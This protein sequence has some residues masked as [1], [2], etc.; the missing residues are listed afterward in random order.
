MAMID[1]DYDYSEYT[2]TDDYQSNNVS[3]DLWGD[4]QKYNYYFFNLFHLMV[5]GR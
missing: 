5:I 2:Q 3:E 4:E 1:N